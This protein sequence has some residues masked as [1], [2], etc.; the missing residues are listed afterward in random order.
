MKDDIKTDFTVKFD[1][2][3]LK[4]IIIL[5]K[6]TGL[7]EK[8]TMKSALGL[9]MWAYNEYKKGKRIGSIM[10]KGDEDEVQFIKLPFMEKNEKSSNSWIK[11]LS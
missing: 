3:A 4:S 6:A 2:E 9:Y 1:Q 11:K 7:D 10:T 8:E 5:S